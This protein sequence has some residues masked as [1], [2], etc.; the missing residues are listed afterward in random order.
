MKIAVRDVRNGET[1]NVLA[2]TAPS[3]RWADSG[4]NKESL[5]RRLPAFRSV[6]LPFSAVLRYNLFRTELFS[7]R[8]WIVASSFYLFGLL[9]LFLL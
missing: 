1:P 9:C 6:P 4:G 8:L 7:L 5:R 3:W 2:I